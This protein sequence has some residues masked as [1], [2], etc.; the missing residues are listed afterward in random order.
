[1]LPGDTLVCLFNLVWTGHDEFR[2]C[3]LKVSSWIWLTT[4]GA[5]RV[6]FALAIDDWGVAI[7]A[8]WEGALAFPPEGYECQQDVDCNLGHN[9]V[10]RVCGKFTSV[11]VAGCYS[12]SDCP[13]AK[14]CS[15]KGGLLGTCQ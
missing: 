6:G 14:S 13:T 9:G 3:E 12:E 15:E 1:M 7:C 4:R 2:L 10:G 5:H 8:N 11:C